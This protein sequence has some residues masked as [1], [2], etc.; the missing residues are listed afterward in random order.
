MIDFAMAEVR[1]Y[2][3]YDIRHGT[4]NAPLALAVK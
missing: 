3:T 1:L 2:L 4:K